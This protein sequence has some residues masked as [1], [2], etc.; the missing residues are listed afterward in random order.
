M[1]QNND[2]KK[3]KDT[4]RLVRLAIEH[5]MTNEQ[6][7]KKAGLS[8]KSISQVSRWRNGQSLAT[9]R[10]LNYFRK[11]FGE[12]LRRKSEH[13]LTSTKDG[14]QVFYKLTGELVLKHVIRA[15]FTLDKRQS[16]AALHRFLIIQSNNEFHLVSQARKGFA[17]S[18]SLTTD[19][20][21]Q[22]SHCDNEDSNWITLQI[23]N[24]L[25]P[26]ELIHMIDAFAC[27]MNNGELIEQQEFKYSAQELQF[28]VRKYLLS[29]GYQHE[30]IIDLSSEK[31]IIN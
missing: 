27:K 8:S 22:M 2:G 20:L 28:K 17:P 15:R 7:A 11:E 12:L 18:A 21:H 19:S 4:K 5:G 1:Q 29:Q 13:L 26:E 30:D 14:D 6:I 24:T 23:F 16:S 31:E 9:E 10:Q 3:C 25:P